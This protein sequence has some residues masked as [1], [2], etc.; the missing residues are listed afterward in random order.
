MVQGDV[1]TGGPA[2]GNNIGSS[3]STQGLFITSYWPVETLRSHIFAAISQLPVA[4]WSIWVGDTG[5]SVHC[6]GDSSHMYNVR[7]P[8]EGEGMLF[9]PNGSPMKVKSIGWLDITMHCE[10]EDMVI[11]LRDIAYV[12]GLSFDL[13][14]HG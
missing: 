6:T 10:G 4:G 5:A 9:V 2:P 8:G 7:V 1:G 11:T 3:M 13:C 14:S 12:P